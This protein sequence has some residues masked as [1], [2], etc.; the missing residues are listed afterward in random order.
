MYEERK[1]KMVQL[2]KE[3]MP[4]REIGKLF[5]ISGQRVH[6]ILSKEVIYKSEFKWI[7]WNGK[8]KQIRLRPKE[9]IELK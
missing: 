3:G 1:I 6:K 8:P 9:R 7:I 2:R 5:S 4:Y